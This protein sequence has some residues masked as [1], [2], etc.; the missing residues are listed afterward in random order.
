[1]E[2]STSLLEKLVSGCWV[3][4]GE[5]GSEGKESA[6]NVGGLSSI[7]G[8]GWSPGEE[9]GNP[10]QYSCLENPV[11]GEACRATVHGVTE[12]DTSEGLHFHLPEMKAACL[13][14]S[15]SHIVSQRLDS[16]A[17]HSPPASLGPE[18]GLLA[19]PSCKGFFFFFLIYFNWN[20]VDLQC[21][22]GFWCAA[23]WMVYISTVF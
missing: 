11:D 2:W 8:S 7:P 17:H 18:L 12:S 20:V 14:E 15:L 9:N 13:L 5:C 10:L 3:K 6:C 21:C 19:S 23:K 1:M 4:S 16:P 22:V